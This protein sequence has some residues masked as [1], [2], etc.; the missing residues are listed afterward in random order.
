RARLE[1]F[2]D[3][4]RR[5]RIAEPEVRL[6]KQKRSIEGRRRFTTRQCLL[7]EGRTKRQSLRVTAA[8]DEGPKK[9]TLRHERD[10]ARRLGASN[11]TAERGLGLLERAEERVIEPDV[12]QGIRNVAAIPH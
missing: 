6:A 11:G 7:V 2:E 9:I 4:P 1:R 12:H 8:Q 3:T 10:H 5:F